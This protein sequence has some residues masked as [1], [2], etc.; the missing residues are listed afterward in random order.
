MD[1][2]F[3]MPRERLVQC[4]PIL[5]NPFKDILQLYVSIVFE[6]TSHKAVILNIVSCPF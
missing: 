2:W 5:L 1:H 6:G 4:A 3:I